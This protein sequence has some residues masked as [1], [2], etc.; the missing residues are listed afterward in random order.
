MSRLEKS[1]S[2]LEEKNTIK[3][4]CMHA[5]NFQRINLKYV[6]NYMFIALACNG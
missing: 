2:A 1:N 3:M 6:K 5:F 4:H